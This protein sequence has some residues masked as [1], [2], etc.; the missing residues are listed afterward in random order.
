MGPPRS[1]HLPRIQNSNAQSVVFRVTLLPLSL[2]A[3]APRCLRPRDA[4]AASGVSLRGAVTALPPRG[5]RP[6]DGSAVPAFFTN[7]YPDQNPNSFIV[8]LR[9]E[10]ARLNNRLT[11][12]HVGGTWLP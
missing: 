10:A 3:G 11:R 7:P 4:P 8:T 5:L 1:D 2:G 6:R 12:P 9:F